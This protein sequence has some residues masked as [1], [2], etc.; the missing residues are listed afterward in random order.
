MLL[1]PRSATRPAVSTV[2][3]WACCAEAHGA[4]KP[5]SPSTITSG[6]LRRS[7]PLRPCASSAARA[8]LGCIGC[9]CASC[10]THDQSTRARY[11]NCLQVEVG[12]VSPII[13]A[14]CTVWLAAVPASGSCKSFLFCDGVSEASHLSSRLMVTW[15]CSEIHV[16]VQPFAVPTIRRAVS[17]TSKPAWRRHGLSPTRQ[18]CTHA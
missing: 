3:I 16:G 14:N 11:A 17:S 5:D 15:C 2:H 18:A 8:F 13:P 7:D 12:S 6:H 1:A 10:Q 4:S 9:Q